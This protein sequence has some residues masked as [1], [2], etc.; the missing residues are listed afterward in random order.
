[1]LEY[2]VVDVFEV[3]EFLAKGWSQ[4]GQPDNGLVYIERLTLIKGAANE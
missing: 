3:D 2:K 1:M 4:I